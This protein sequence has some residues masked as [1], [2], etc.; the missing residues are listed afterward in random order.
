MLLAVH[1]HHLPQEKVDFSFRGPVGDHLGQTPYIDPNLFIGRY[2]EITEM[3]KVLKPGG[4]SQEQRRL[5]LGGM[6]GIGKTQLAIAYTTRHHNDYESVFWLNATSIATLKEDF[7]SMAEIIFGIQDAEGLKDDQLV[8][9]VRRWLSDQKN[10][11]WLVI[12]DNYDDP[13]QFKIDQYYPSASHGAIIV[14]TRRPDRV[15]GKPVRVQP[16]DDVEESLEIL[17]TR[18]RRVNAKSGML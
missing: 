3:E 18:S 17:Q 8:T 7:R 14:T 16:L 13:D 15:A 1:H 2:S 6:G 9:E 12:F 10:K 5:V 4:I 11:Q